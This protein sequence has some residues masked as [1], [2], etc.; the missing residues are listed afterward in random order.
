M[1]AQPDAEAAIEALQRRRLQNRIAQRNRLYLGKR[2]ADIEQQRLKDL[3]NQT[4]GIQQQK[5]GNT[6]APNNSECHEFH[7]SNLDNTRNKPGGSQFN[8]NT[9]NL[10]C[11]D[12]ETLQ[13]EAMNRGPSD[14]I[15]P[16]KLTGQNE[17]PGIATS[18]SGMKNINIFDAAMEEMPTAI[19]LDS[20]PGIGSSSTPSRASKNQ[21]T[22]QAE[23]KSI[24]GQN[25]KP[26]ESPQ[27]SNHTAN[28]GKTALH[29]S[30]ERGNLGIVRLLLQYGVNVD[31]RDNLGRTALYYAACGAH[32]DIVG[33]LLA[34]GADPEACDN[35]GRSPLHA[36]AYA[37]S[38]AV[39]RLLVREGVDLNVAIGPGGSNNSE[40]MD[41]VPGSMIGLADGFHMYDWTQI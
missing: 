11:F 41:G 37:E 31:R 2:Q 27:Y 35:E 16:E 34:G 4:R 38:E 12:S 7:M 25:M 10:A 24:H 30:V 6:C 26:W 28:K 22:P 32:I 17:S 21:E 36:A 5:D 15:H 40:D 29:I 20:D 13:A 3:E 1:D 33:E 23:A 9:P 19:G 39:I 8:G 18:V 14:A